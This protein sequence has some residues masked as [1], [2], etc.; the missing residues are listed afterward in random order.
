LADRDIRSKKQQNLKIHKIQWCVMKTKLT[1]YLQLTKPRVMLLVMASAA[2]ALALEGS[3]LENPVEFLLIMSSIFLAGGSANAFNQYFERD[4][5]A[6]M[7]RTCGRRPL[8]LKNLTPNQALVFA[9]I[10]GIAS[11]LIFALAFNWLSALLAMATILFYGLFYTLWLKPHTDQNIVIGG[12]AGAMA[13]IIAWAA[14]AGT[15]S[16]TPVLM[17]LVIFIWTPPHFWALALYFK[18]D[19]KKA[20]LP[21]LPIVRGEK[22]TLNHICFYSGML[23]VVSLGF[24]AIN[25]GT[26]YGGA[27]LILGGI[28]LRKA[29]MTRKH[30]LRKLQHALFEYSTVYLL[31]LFFAMI[32]DNIIL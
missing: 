12:A 16:L 10:I 6:C 14:A 23:L 32:I 17:S 13:P 5:D 19:Y 29:F 27:A 11:I 7:T 9:V 30:N 20:G 26:V 15:I 8:P 3:V 28:F 22:S 18:E 31:I 21:M 1:S 24:L 2:T 25:F 4:I